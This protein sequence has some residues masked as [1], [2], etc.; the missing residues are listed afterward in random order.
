MLNKDNFIGFYHENEK[1]GCF[2]NWYPS[3]FEYAGKKYAN[4]EQY[5]M[6]QKMYTFC[7]FDLA[8]KIMETTDPAECK[9]LGRTHISNWDGSL[10]E[11]ISYTIVKRGVKAKFFQNKELLKKLLST[12][13]TILAEC[14]PNDLKWGIGIAIDDNRR[15]DVREWRGHNY[16]GRILMEVRDEMINLEWI[17]RKR[18]MLRG[19]FDTRE[20][21]FP[22]WDMTFGELIRV[23]KYH[24]T[25]SA[26]REVCKWFGGKDILK[27]SPANAEKMHRTNMG[28]GLPLAGFW[29]FKQDFCEILMDMFINGCGFDAPAYGTPLPPE[30]RFV[31]QADGLFKIVMPGDDG[32][33]DA[34]KR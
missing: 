20:L 32:Y 25:V 4:I 21:Q 26:Y 13:G 27:F 22:E 10:W 14:A 5:M 30:A 28:G 31:K 6:Y 23:P 16:L 19:Y 8:D 9:R 2:S 17:S 12:R 11:K 15:F 29:E 3:E 1:Y 24:D 33:D 7:Q 34:E 18:L